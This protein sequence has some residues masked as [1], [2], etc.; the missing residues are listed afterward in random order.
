MT[1]ADVRA[2]AVICANHFVGLYNRT[3]QAAV[4]QLIEKDE[5]LFDVADMLT[6]DHCRLNISRR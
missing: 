1:L 3:N 5:L 6:S 4:A 2:G